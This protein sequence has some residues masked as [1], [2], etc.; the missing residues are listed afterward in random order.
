MQSYNHL[1]SY[2]HLLQ[3]PAT[4]RGLTGAHGLCYRTSAEV[5]VATPSLTP[6]NPSP[7]LQ[8]SLPFAYTL[9]SVQ[10]TGRRTWHA[11][12]NYAVSRLHRVM[13]QLTHDFDGEQHQPRDLCRARLDLWTSRR[14]RAAL[15]QEDPDRVEGD[16]EKVVEQHDGFRR[17]TG[18]VSGNGPSCRKAPLRDCGK[19]LTPR[20]SRRV[21]RRIPRRA[22]ST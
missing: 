18:V 9:N 15:G 21:Q 3:C 16:A 11:V 17:Q 20:G 10:M 14:G 12:Q 4:A 22:E 1:Y 7:H 13:S 6:R 2:I 19:P 8:P 5:A